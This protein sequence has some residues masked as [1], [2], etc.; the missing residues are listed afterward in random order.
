M[1]RPATGRGENVAKHVRR[2]SGVDSD[3]TF[4]ISSISVTLY[5]E[6]LRTVFVTEAA[7]LVFL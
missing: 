7:V 3:V 1:V 6:V 5:F 2:S 4:L